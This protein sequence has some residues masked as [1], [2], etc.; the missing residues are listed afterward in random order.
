M[1]ESI[2]F[3]GFPKIPRLVRSC[4]ITEKLDGTNA[5]VIITGDGQIGAA[6]RSRLITPEDDNYGFARWVQE[7]QQELLTL[8]PGRHFGE[9]W[10]AGIQRRYGL[11]EKRFSLF[12]TAR[13]AEDRP[14]CCDVV[15]VLY[16]GDFTTHAVD[17]QIERLRGCGS[18]AAPGFRNPEG[19][20]VYHAASGQLFKRLIENDD[21]PK[22]TGK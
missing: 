15:P 10:G 8:G 1:I 20:V 21:Q 11:T 18:V 9:W 6:S 12:N 13:W 2:T 14:K 16:H 3:E 19:V 4:V 22:G 5:Q 7:N 17:H